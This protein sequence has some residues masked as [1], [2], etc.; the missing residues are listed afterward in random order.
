MVLLEQLVLL[1]TIYY[2]RAL[3]DDLPDF[4]GFKFDSSYV[5]ICFIC[6]LQRGA[7]PNRDKLREIEAKDEEL[8]RVIQEQEKYKARKARHK[9]KQMSERQR[10][11]TAIW[12][13]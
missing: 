10:Q 9:L 13:N 12:T 4:C 7:V 3:Q 8:A 2:L 1:N 11:V 6:F 5:L